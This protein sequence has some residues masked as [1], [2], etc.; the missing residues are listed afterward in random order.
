MNQLVPSV[1]AAAGLVRNRSG[2]RQIKDVLVLVLLTLGF[3][4]HSEG[5]KEVGKYQNAVCRRLCLSVCARLDVES[6]W[7]WL[8]A[9]CFLLLA[10]NEVCLL[11]VCD[12][13]HHDDKRIPEFTRVYPSL[14]G[15]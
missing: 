3:S 1:A 7:W 12:N 11:R 2:M 10:S 15:H 9:S 5:K 13:I 14:P 4:G 6:K 8:A